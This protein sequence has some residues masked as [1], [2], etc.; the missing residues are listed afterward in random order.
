M[1]LF[2]DCIILLDEFN[3]LIARSAEVKLI[4][5]NWIK[6]LCLSVLAKKINGHCWWYNQA[7]SNDEKSTLI[8][9]YN[10][11]YIECRFNIEFDANQ[12]PK[13]YLSSLS[14]TQEGC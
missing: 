12:P 5:E 7:L 8:N 14:F 10:G 1:L 11:V 4:Y 3:R 13:S 9:K 2:F 6:Q